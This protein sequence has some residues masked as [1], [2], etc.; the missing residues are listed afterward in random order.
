MNEFKIVSNKISFEEFFIDD[1][2]DTITYYFICEDKKFTRQVFADFDGSCR[3]D[4]AGFTV[5]VE[6]PYV[7]GKPLNRYPMTMISPFIKDGDKHIVIDWGEWDF[8]VDE[9]EELMNVGMKHYMETMEGRTE[10]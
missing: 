3:E 1:E 10:R 7:Y 2:E 8:L 9:V 4:I 6:I 5:S